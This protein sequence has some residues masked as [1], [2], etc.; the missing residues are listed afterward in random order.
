MSRGPIPSGRTSVRIVVVGDRA[1]E[2]FSLIA[3]AT[4]ETFYQ[5]VP[6]VLPPTRLPVDF[7][8][9]NVPITII[10][11]SSRFEFVCV[12][13]NFTTDLCLTGLIGFGVISIHSLE[14]RW[15]LAEELKRADAV[16]LTYTCDQLTM[17]NRISSFWIYELRTKIFPTSQELATGNWSSFLGWLWWRVNFIVP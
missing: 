3:A 11:T 17:I 6:P 15:R 8:P 12:V 14:F 9:D 2:K 4:S 1:T 5:E 13:A 16:V 10:D 7:Y